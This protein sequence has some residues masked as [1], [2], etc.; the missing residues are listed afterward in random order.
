MS[1]H[2]D[3]LTT[4]ALLTRWDLTRGC[5]DAQ[6][7]VKLVRD[8]WSLLVL[9]SGDTPTSAWVLPPGGADYDSIDVPHV[10]RWM[11]CS[12][13]EMALYEIGERVTVGGRAGTVVGFGLEERPP[14]AGPWRFRLRVVY[15]DG[16]DGDPRPASVV[17]LAP[18]PAEAGE[19][20]GWLCGEV[21]ALMCLTRAY[22]VHDGPI[23]RKTLCEF[24]AKHGDRRLTVVRV[25]H[26]I[27]TQAVA[28]A[29][30]DRRKA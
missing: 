26:E 22:G 1:R 29:A 28:V 12:S 25:L 27:V 15:D 2:Q 13:E 11:K 10:D 20:E 16:V 14:A 18:A 24:H 23:E 7:T 6:L 30:D 21:G 9:Y 19:C 3:L 8:R 5:D 4:K 17:H